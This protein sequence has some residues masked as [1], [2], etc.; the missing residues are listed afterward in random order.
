MTKAQKQLKKKSAFKSEFESVFTA[1][2]AR[3]IWA[4]AEKRLD[5]MYQKYSS[6]PKGVRMHTDLYIFPAA[7]MYL[8][9]KEFSQ[10]K[11]FAVMQKVMKEK[12]TKSGNQMN[13]LSKLPG[14]KSLILKIW[15]VMSHKMFSESAGFRNVFYPKQKGQF[16]MDIVQC[17]YN[18]YLSEL[19]CPELARLFC[20]NDIYQHGNL[21]G[22]KFV[23]TQ[24]IATGGD[25]CD[26]MM[27]RE[28]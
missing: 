22:L 28:K 7:A 20:E 2:E 5:E 16:K 27:V 4:N 8:S 14:G 25:K 1:D 10:E 3:S 23:R 9:A 18:T 13:R 6:L 15:D 17:P 11:A 24:T 12:A 26:F 21:T 19:G